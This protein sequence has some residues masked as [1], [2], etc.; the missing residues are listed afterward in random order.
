[1]S[2]GMAKAVK[3]PTHTDPKSAPLKEIPD[4]LVD[5]RSM[6]RYMRGRFLGKGGFAKCYE[7]TDMDTKEVFAGKVVPKS[8][9][10][11]PHQ[12]EKMSTEIAIHKSLDNPHVVGF[13]GFFENDDFVF[14]VLEICRRRVRCSLSLTALRECS[15]GVSL[16]FRVFTVYY[17]HV[18]IT[19]YSVFNTDVVLAFSG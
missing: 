9:L 17:P 16:G 11:K 13:H 18:N 19:H 2:A 12:K 6:K 7:I 8:L 5:P 4:I 1:M 15:T 14:V 3:P 10:M